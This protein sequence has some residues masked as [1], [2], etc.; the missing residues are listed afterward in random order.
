MIE[1][2]NQLGIQKT[3]AKQLNDYYLVLL[4]LNCTSE[5]DEIEDHKNLF[6]PPVSESSPEKKKEGKTKI[7]YSKSATQTLTKELFG[8]GIEL[9]KQR[10][11][12]ISDFAFDNSSNS[13]NI[14]IGL[15]ASGI[16]EI[17]ILS[18]LLFRHR[19]E[20]GHQLIDDE[21]LRWDECLHRYDPIE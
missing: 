8:S 14:A 20:N 17:P 3:F 10:G 21:N 2:W 9:F 18:T 6:H 16:R 19:I 11:E 5:Q 15:M 13:N 4:A 12:Q 7:K 1:F